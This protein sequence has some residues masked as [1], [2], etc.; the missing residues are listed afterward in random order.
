M[1]LGLAAAKYKLEG[2]KV[3]FKNTDRRQNDP[4]SSHAYLIKTFESLHNMRGY[5]TDPG[6]DVEKF[7]EREQQ[8]PSYNFK[9]TKTITD[10]AKGILIPSTLSSH[11]RSI[12]AI[13]LIYCSPSLD[14][15]LSLHLG[16][17]WLGVYLVVWFI[18]WKDPM[19]CK[20][21]DRTIRPI[22]PRLSSAYIPSFWS[23]E[24]PL[25]NSCV[26][27]FSRVGH[28]QIYTYAELRFRSSACMLGL[29]SILFN[30]FPNTGHCLHTC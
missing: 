10:A 25:I 3:F 18:P 16:E 5:Y 8:L 13:N 28:L 12:L 30:C 26:C 17:S 4:P 21:V 24:I 20:S 29:R 2:W 14:P 22:I 7:F 6:H 15:N 19:F 27:L 1:S 11:L 9:R 23:E